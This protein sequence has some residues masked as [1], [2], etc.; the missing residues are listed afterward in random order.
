MSSK[1][2]ISEIIKGHFQT[3][4]SSSTQKLSFSDL[5]TF[6]ILPLSIAILT[7]IYDF[8]Q[9]DQMSHF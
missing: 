8:K 1:I 5:F 6:I 4:Q 9:S 2:N 3:L 7:F